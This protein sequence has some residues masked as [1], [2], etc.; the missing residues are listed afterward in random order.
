MTWRRFCALISGLSG[1]SVLALKI[2]MD[3]EDAERENKKI[4]DPNMI[5]K[6]MQSAV[7]G[8]K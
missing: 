7:V 3:E 1:E 6:L 8:K 2:R 5:A 4:K